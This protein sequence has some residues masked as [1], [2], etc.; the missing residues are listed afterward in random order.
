MLL[1]QLL[2]CVVAQFWSQKLLPNSLTVSVVPASTVFLGRSLSGVVDL[3]SGLPVCSPGHIGPD[4]R[5]TLGQVVVQVHLGEAAE[6]ARG[7]V[8]GLT[9]N[10]PSLS[11]VLQ[12]KKTILTWK[13]T[14]SNT[15]DRSAELLL[16]LVHRHWSAPPASEELC[17]LMLMKLKMLMKV[18]LCAREGKKS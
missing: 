15:W 13:E 7:D 8:S 4:L 1:L 3:A 9:S 16:V 14:T 2:S 18:L 12:I 11:A 5:Q 6:P 10:T 17:C